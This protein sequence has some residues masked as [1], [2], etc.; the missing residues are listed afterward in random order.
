MRKAIGLASLLL[1][2]SGAPAVATPLADISAAVG[3]QTCTPSC[4]LGWDFTASVPFVVDALGMWDA[5]SNG[6]VVSHDVG[7]WTAT[8]TLLASTT[9]TNGN[10]T[11][12]A[13]AA[14]AGRWLFTPIAPLLLSPGSYVLGVHG[15]LA[16]TDLTVGGTSV[17][18]PAGFTFGNERGVTFS[19]TLVF[20]DSVPNPLVTG[21]FGP[22]LSVTAI[23][24][25]TTLTLLGI[26]LLGAA[27]LLR[28]RKKLTR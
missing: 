1:V 26:G 18:T 22:N 10:S 3:G 13:S 17:I 25:P 28:R 15:A 24:E 12:T 20:P 16:G 21:W 11:P 6:L 5:G 23:P 4:V 9:V 7:L 8:G 27:T 14:A 2:L 19:P